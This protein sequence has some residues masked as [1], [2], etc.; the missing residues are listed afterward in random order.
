MDQSLQSSTSNALNT[1]HR[2]KMTRLCHCILSSQM[3]EM[4]HALR[5]LMSG[6]NMLKSC[7]FLAAVYI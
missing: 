6:K 3:F 4:F 2:E 5:A 1:H 7:S